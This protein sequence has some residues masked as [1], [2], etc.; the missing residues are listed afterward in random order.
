MNGQRDDDDF[1]SPNI[2]CIVL[3]SSTLLG[4]LDSDTTATSIFRNYAFHANC[5]D[6]H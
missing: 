4:I 2:L 5:V 1:Q 3:V 6:L